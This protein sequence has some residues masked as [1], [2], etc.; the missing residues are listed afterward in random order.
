MGEAEEEAATPDR[1]E[2][3]WEPITELEVLKALTA[4]K[5]TTVPG[6]DGIPTL[7][8]KHLWQYMGKPISRIF[9]A[10]NLPPRDEHKR[11]TP[12]ILLRSYKE[13]FGTWETAQSRIHVRTPR[14]SNGA[15]QTQEDDLYF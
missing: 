14:P 13:I 9:T 12:K 7:V 10:S 2:I 5:E 1:E 3:H 11:V 6:E 15:G 8:W 4:A